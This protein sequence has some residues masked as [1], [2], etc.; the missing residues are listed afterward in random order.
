MA[1]GGG[2]RRRRGRAL[3][4]GALRGLIAG[5][6][7]RGTCNFD[8]LARLENGRREMFV[9]GAP[10]GPARPH[11][12]EDTMSIAWCPFLARDSAWTM[13]LHAA[14]REGCLR[15]VRELCSTPAS[16][17]G[18]R[19][20]LPRGALATLCTVLVVKDSTS[21]RLPLRTNSANCAG[22]ETLVRAT[23]PLFNTDGTAVPC[24]TV[25]CGMRKYNGIGVQVPILYLSTLAVV[26]HVPHARAV[27][28][29]LVRDGTL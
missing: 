7:A 15:V 18:F 22:G 19:R 4:R 24:W 12:N 16:S 25:S 13:G 20:F 28:R 5:R 2:A 6:V 1:R 11:V 17:D 9:A 26:A 23:S 21:A 14:A 10:W 29:C 3:C 8:N 27:R